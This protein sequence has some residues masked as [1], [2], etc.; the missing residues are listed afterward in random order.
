MSKL[1]Y[2]DS[3]ARLVSERIAKPVASLTV[4]KQIPANKR[5]SG[6][7]AHVL[8]ANTFWQFNPDSTLTGDDVLVVAP[9]AGSGRWLRMP[10]AA[11]LALPIHATY[12]TGTN[13]LTIPTGCIIAP[14]DFGYRVSAGFTGASNCAIAV[15]SS[16]HPGHTGIAA[17]GGTLVA[18]QLNNMFSATAAATGLAFQMMPIA[19][20][21]FD[22]H[23]NKRTWM[24]PGDTVR[25][26]VIGAQFATGSG[27]V[28]M[29]C[30]ILQNTGE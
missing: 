8:D 10:G 14:H 26:D 28:L 1:L 15:S 17:F 30:D 24:R 2:G 22:S 21:T 16:N 7:I 4:L 19:S 29:A 12:A 20:G 18:T 5:V 3:A 9:N 25:L 23:A 27:E 11:M 6:M 13:L